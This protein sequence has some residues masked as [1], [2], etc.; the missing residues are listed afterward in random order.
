MT[1]LTLIASFQAK[2]GTREQLERRLQEMVVRTTGEQ[3]CAR[4]DLHID[5]DNA[6]RFVFIE[7]W[8]DKAAWEKHMTTDHVKRLLADAATLTTEGI[9]LEKL[10]QI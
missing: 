7:T 1:A 8:A 5:A 10:R 2:V 3:G 4:Y 9:R 6:Y